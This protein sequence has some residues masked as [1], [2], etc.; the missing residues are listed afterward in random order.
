MR[1]HQPVKGSRGGFPLQPSHSSGSSARS[2]GTPPQDIPRTTV[3]ELGNPQINKLTCSG[4]GHGDQ[5]RQGWGPCPHGEGGPRYSSTPHSAPC[6]VPQPSPCQH[7]SGKALDRPLLPYYINLLSINQTP[8][9]KT[10][11]PA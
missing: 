8:H 9:P 2:W 7:Q 6:G 4:L 10:Q 1:R 3:P 11:F 5:R